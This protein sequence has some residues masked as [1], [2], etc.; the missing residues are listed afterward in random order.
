[1]GK[2]AHFT[3][4][5]LVTK[6]IDVIV[7]YIRTC[8]IHFLHQFSRQITIVYLM[9]FS[10]HIGGI[11]NV[12]CST[13]TLVSIMCARANFCARRSKC[14]CT[15]LLS[16]AYLLTIADIRVNIP[17]A[18]VNLKAKECS[19]V[20]CHL[21]RQ[22]AQRQYFVNPMKRVFTDVNDTNLRM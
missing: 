11:E 14:V 16:R 5:H 1:M 10:W 13:C 9:L 15:N 22:R 3:S 2:H 19:R 21:S 12:L 7:W 8:A 17:C 18:S 4:V 6:C 20:D